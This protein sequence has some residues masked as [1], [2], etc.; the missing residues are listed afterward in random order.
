MSDVESAAAIRNGENEL[1]AAH[2]PSARVNVNVNANAGA[3]ASASASASARA[4]KRA[5]VS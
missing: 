2:Q 3:S 4:G 5:G 1:G